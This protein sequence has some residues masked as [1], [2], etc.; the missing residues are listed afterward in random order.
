MRTVMVRYRVRPDKAG[1]NVAYIQKVFEEMQRSSPPGL[2]YASFK[3][4]D[5][6]S[7]VHIAS[8]ETTDGSNPLTESVAFKAFQ[9][10]IKDRCEEQPV[11]TEMTAIGSYRFLG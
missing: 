1:E 5:G 10:G 2:R 8:V 4:S 9:A 6:V 11:A 7:F 3:L